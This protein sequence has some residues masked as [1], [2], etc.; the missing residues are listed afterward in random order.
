M[1]CT[2]APR[3]RVRF[4]AAWQ[5]AGV[6]RGA[7]SR[8]DALVLGVSLVCALSASALAA[9]APIALKFLLDALAPGDAGAGA[10][11]A[12]GLYLLAYTGALWLA[13]MAGEGRMVFAARAEQAFLRRLGARSFAHALALPPRAHA[14]RST[15]SL[16]QI[17]ENGLQGYRLILQHALSTVLPGLAEIILIGVLAALFLDLP[18]L[19][20]FA[21][22]ALGYGF[23]FTAGAASALRLGRKVSKARVQVTSRLADAML[24]I[25]AVKALGGE[26]RVSGQ[27]DARLADVQA[28]WAAFYQARLAN[29]VLAGT[30]F[31]AGLGAALWLAESRIAAGRMSLGDLALI[32]AW[33]L[34]AMRPLELIGT[35]LRDISQGAAFAGRLSAVLAEPPEE[36]GLQPGACPVA[37]GGG[38]AVRFDNVSYAY[39]GTRRV[40]DGVSFEI[41]PGATAAL[42][43]PSGSGKSTLLRLLLRFDRPQSGEILIDGVPLDQ[44]PYAQLRAMIAPV[45]Q[46]TAVFNDSLRDNLA[47][48]LEDPGPERLSRALYLAGLEGL[49]ERLPQGLETRLGERGANLSG[50]ERQRLAIARAS[51]RPARLY[52]ADEASSALDAETEALISRRA[53]RAPSGRTSLIVAHR[54][55]SIMHADTILV[56]DGGR[57]AEQGRHADLCAGD[58]LYAKLWR[59]QTGG[60]RC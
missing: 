52:L 60:P 18:F 17:L 37:P 2:A 12:P 51:L 10:P 35:G 56:L 25:E 22:C 28:R 43:G 45:L 29:G 59:T 6:L 57:I 4:S 41:A 15:G 19:W 42:V 36:D 32:N 20:V 49:P 23:V 26:A 31:V 1:A 11:G 44:Y 13:R 16:I 50:G 30:V 3:G 39:D 46:Q 47:F 24:N 55:A 38:A 34:Q 8:A 48:P 21:G 33:M 9:L 27:L 58:G 5:M 53:V 7:L 54:L 40:L 14:G